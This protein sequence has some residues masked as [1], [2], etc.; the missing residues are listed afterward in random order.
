MFSNVRG[1]CKKKMGRFRWFGSTEVPDED[2]AAEA[3][4][5]K[6]LLNY[7]VKTGGRLGYR[8]E[9]ADI[10]CSLDT[11]DR[12]QFAV[13]DPEDPD[14]DADLPLEKRRQILKQYGDTV[15]FFCCQ[16]GGWNRIFL[17]A[18]SD[19]LYFGEHRLFDVD[20]L[21]D[22]FSCREVEDDDSWEIESDRQKSTMTLNRER[23]EE[24]RDASECSCAGC[25]DRVWH[26]R[27]GNALDWYQTH[28]QYVYMVA[29]VNSVQPQEE[30]TDSTRDDSVQDCLQ[31]PDGL[32]FPV[33]YRTQRN[34]RPGDPAREKTRVLH[35]GRS[36]T[37]VCLCVP[38][39]VYALWNLPPPRKEQ[40]SVGAAK[41]NGFSV[42][43]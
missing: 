13:L 7:Q 21:R 20:E 41:V 15:R 8:A 19:G 39:Q 1:C 42:L 25:V 12:F 36:G 40:K 3:V 10:L 9:G 30:A 26:A 32:E 34:S 43:Q 23:L 2:D 22:K 24:A 18:R 38:L 31:R 27:Q 17:S 4:G 16:Q 37:H 5:W 29:Y 14:Y 6:D 11:N 28:P 33:T 35:V